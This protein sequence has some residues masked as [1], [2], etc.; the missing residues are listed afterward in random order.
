MGI[1]PEK[2]P[3][4]FMG[5]HAEI[6]RQEQKDSEGQE[7]IGGTGMTE[8]E[9]FDRIEYWKQKAIEAANRAC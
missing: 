8:R 5:M 2:Y 3:V 9:A 6:R 4:L 1:P 7:R